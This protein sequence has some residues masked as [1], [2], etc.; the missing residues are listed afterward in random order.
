[1]LDLKYFYVDG[2]RRLELSMFCSVSLVFD[3]VEVEAKVCVCVGGR[4]MFWEFHP[5]PHH[6]PVLLFKFHCPEP[7]HTVKSV[8]CLYDQSLIRLQ[9]ERK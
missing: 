2:R 3:I 9:I 4:V 8:F 1:M 6:P 5:S 7:I